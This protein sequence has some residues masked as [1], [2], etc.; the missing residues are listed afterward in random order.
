MILDVSINRAGL[1]LLALV[2][3]SAA[4]EDADFDHRFRERRV[5]RWA[6]GVRNGMSLLS[7]LRFRFLGGRVLTFHGVPVA[8][9][10]NQVTCRLIEDIW[11]RGEY[12]LPGF[13]PAPGWRVVDIGGNVGVFAMLAAGRGARVV[14]YEP[15]PDSFRRLREHTAKWAVQCHH[16]A[17]VGHARGPVELLVHERHTRHSLMRQAGVAVRGAVTVP[18]VSISEVLAEPCDLLK[19]DCEG[20]EF[21]LLAAAGPALRQARRIIAELDAAAGDPAEAAQTVRR[22]GFDV[23]LHEPFPGLGFQ[24]MTAVRREAGG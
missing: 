12:D 24:L 15:H 2:R 3:R 20:S 4:G 1:P 5:R 19:I 11:M 16:A 9:T 14:S 10:D 8:V 7:L 17:V 13:I 6:R 18:S 21:E 23:T 22:N